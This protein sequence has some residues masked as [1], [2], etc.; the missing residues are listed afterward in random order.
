[1]FNGY[2]I[3]NPPGIKQCCQEPAPYQAS[4]FA[5]IPGCDLNT[6]TLFAYTLDPMAANVS[7]GTAY[8]P[9]FGQQVYFA[10]DQLVPVAPN[11]GPGTPYPLGFTPEVL[12][13]IFQRQTIWTVTCNFTFSGTDNNGNPYGATNVLTT[14]FVVPKCGCPPVAQTNT[15]PNLTVSLF[16]GSIAGG[17]WAYL[18][19]GLIYPA[20]YLHMSFHPGN[21]DLLTSYGFTSFDTCLKQWHGSGIYCAQAVT[22]APVIFDE[23]QVYDAL[24]TRCDVGSAIQVQQG[25]IDVNFS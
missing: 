4:P 16:D 7:D 24:T 6:G 2:Q 21:W 5:A 18:C 8:D 11:V 17:D 22:N 19:N 9:Y 25:G 23:S 10:S 14:E 15:Q 3:L 12:S 1:M 20:I 13:T